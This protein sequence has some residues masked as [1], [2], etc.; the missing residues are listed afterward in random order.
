MSEKG[1]QKCVLT[2][3]D[4]STCPSF[5]YILQQNSSEYYLDFFKVL[6]AQTSLNEEKRRVANAHFANP[7]P[8]YPVVSSVCPECIFAL[9]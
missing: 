6:S 9:C 8:N 5:Y 2:P 3:D 1:L 7:C 4:R